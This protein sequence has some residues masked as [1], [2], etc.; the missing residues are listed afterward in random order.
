MRL[1]PLV[2]VV[3]AFLTA[4]CRQDIN[5]LH[6]RNPWKAISDSHS[7]TNELIQA[8]RTV[9][10]M[11]IT[12]EPS[13]YWSAIAN[14][15]RYSVDHRRRAALQL[16]ARHFRRG[17]TVQQLGSLFDHANWF[18]SYCEEFSMGA[19]PPGT[20]PD[21]NWFYI[22]ILNDH[23]FSPAVWFKFTGSLPGTMDDL[24]KCLKGDPVNSAVHEIRVTDVFS[25]E[26]ISSNV[27]D[28]N[29]FGVPE[30]NSPPFP[31]R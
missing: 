30:T 27:S 7:T 29:C 20:G 23:H 31:I 1:A 25:D 5:E 28:Y 21:D 14:N 6:S 2:L 12:N 22:I 3:F 8:L 4:S 18:D 10:A 9:K 17:M 19:P 24:C 26:P 13:K 16:V 15:P 11:K